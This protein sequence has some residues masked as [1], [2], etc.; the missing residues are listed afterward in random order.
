MEFS[1]L[2][3]YK[4][5]DK[6]AIRF[7]DTV[8]L[9][10]ADTT[11]KEGM[12]VKTKGYYEADDGG[13]G[14]YIIVNDNNL[15]SDNGLVHTLNNELKAKLIENDFVTPEQYGAYGDGI[16]DDT[17]V[18]QSLLNTNKKIKLSKKYKTLSTLNVDVGFHKGISGGGI[19][20]N[21]STIE[22]QYSTFTLTNSLYPDE[23]T[24]DAYY[25]S[26][27]FYI[28]DLTITNINGDNY[29]DSV[30]YGNGIQFGDG[31]NRITVE[32][33]TIKNLYYGILSRYANV[34]IY[35]NKINRC[36]IYANEYNIWLSATS[37]SGENITFNECQIFGAK[38]GNKIEQNMYVNFNN[39]SIDYNHDYI[40]YILGGS[41][42]VCSNCHIEWGQPNRAFLL[43]N[44]CSLKFYGCTI[45][46]SLTDTCDYMIYCNNS[47]P[48]VLFDG[49]SFMSSQT[50]TNLCNNEAFIEFNNCDR[51]E[52]SPMAFTNPHN[53][54]N[55]I[56]ATNYEYPLG[57]NTQLTRGTN[58]VIVTATTKD[59]AN[60]LYLPLDY[61]KNRDGKITMKIDSSEDLDLTIS[62]GDTV[63]MGDGYDGTWGT[64]NHTESIV[65]NTITT[66]E[67]EFKRRKGTST[68]LY[69]MFNLSNLSASAWF[70]VREINVQVI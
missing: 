59:N 12:H 56:Q 28:K 33:C 49:C 61:F 35:L 46:H 37:D 8:A 54:V 52:T 50:Y 69:V 32:N 9:M 1:T 16:H 57:Y 66:K 65:A 15:V 42:V 63:F 58:Q 44:K 43:D 45:I 70:R 53:T 36:S 67:Y 3:G 68:T 22:N 27:K 41:N 10:K 17:L 18:L 60:R 31:C 13:N 64:T 5:K 23:I 47:Y 39:C 55:L 19:I 26:A 7:Y 6:K 38:I 62:I 30:H 25:D 14:E 24:P 20:L 2:N 21:T 48:Y 29:T 51:L 11:L 4:V 34:G 40:F